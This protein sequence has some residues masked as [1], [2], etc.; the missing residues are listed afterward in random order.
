MIQKKNNDNGHIVCVCACVYEEIEL[1]NMANDT[2]EHLGNLGG[3]D[4]EVLCTVLSTFFIS[5]K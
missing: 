1:L 2:F 4:M 5:L 3:G